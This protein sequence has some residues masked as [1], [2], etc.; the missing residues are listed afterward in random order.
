[1]MAEK[2]PEASSCPDF[3]QNLCVAA[4]GGAKKG[5]VKGLGFKRSRPSNFTTC[6]SA[7]S[8]VA[9]GSTATSAPPTSQ[10]SAEELVKA[11][12][13][14]QNLMVMLKQAMLSTMSA[15]EIGL[16]LAGRAQSQG[17]ANTQSPPPPAA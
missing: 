8:A 10:Q 14:D 15:E 17:S 4:S 11:L 2:Y 9:G 13:T 5:Y 6:T 3:D 7:S 16:Y 1:M 12:C